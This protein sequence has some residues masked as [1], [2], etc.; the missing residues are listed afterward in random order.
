MRLKSQEADCAVAR[1]RAETISAAIWTN[2]SRP[3]PDWRD[4]HSQVLYPAEKFSFEMSTRKPV[5]SG[6]SAFRT[7]DPTLKPTRS[8]SSPSGNTIPPLNRG[9]RS[10]EHTSE[11]QSLMSISYAVFC[12][13]KK[14]K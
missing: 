12:L 2:R 6:R 1:E 5:P 13:K 9:L 14:K 8:V 7:S 11:L 3:A 10:E 4:R